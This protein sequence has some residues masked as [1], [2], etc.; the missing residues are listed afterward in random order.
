MERDMFWY[1]VLY[2]ARFGR[3]D[4]TLPITKLGSRIGIVLHL[5]GYD[6]RHILKP[7]ER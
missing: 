2:G 1:A 7:L 5:F 6:G 4:S 3:V